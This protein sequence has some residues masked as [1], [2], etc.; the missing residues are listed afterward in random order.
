MATIQQRMR[1]GN[2]NGLFTPPRRPRRSPLPPPPPAPPPPGRWR[3]APRAPQPAGARSRQA[4][5]LGG[6]AA[7]GIL[8]VR[9]GHQPQDREG[10]GPDDSPNAPLPGGRGD[11]IGRYRS[12][13]WAC[14]T[15]SREQTMLGLASRGGGHL[16]PNAGA[17]PDCLQRPL[18]PRSRFRQQ[19]S[20]SVR[21]HSRFRQ[22]NHKEGTYDR[23][24]RHDHQRD[25][26]GA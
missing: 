12:A 8:E 22:P 19:V 25:N 14:G 1:I 5:L 2:S 3:A 6:A 15:D 4:P 20:A 24:T 21:C 7:K 17:A 9:A 26:D 11:E 16:Q 13:L 10:T 18:V 23:A